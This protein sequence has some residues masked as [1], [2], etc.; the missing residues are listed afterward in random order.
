[1][2]QINV[3]E[4]EISYK[5]LTGRICLYPLEL[6]GSKDLICL[7]Y[8]NVLKRASRFILELNTAKNTDYY[9]KGCK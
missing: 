4:N 5:K 1:M 8:Y 2:F 3:D 6:V 9:E 7:K